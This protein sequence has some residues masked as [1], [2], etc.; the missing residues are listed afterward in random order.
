M[1]TVYRFYYGDEYL[2]YGKHL[3]YLM[4]ISVIIS[5]Y[6]MDRIE[7]TFQSVNSILGQKDSD[8]EI[9]VV[10]DRNAELVAI[11]REHF[12]DAIRI[13]VSDKKG[14]SRA[15]NLG[16]KH[17]K[18][19]IVAFIDDD[20][21]A[22]DGWVEGIR[23]ALSGDP[24]IGA[25]T[26]PIFPEWLGEE[27]K[28]FPKELNWMI[29]C[30]YSDIEDGA[31]VD[32]AF[33][34]NMAFRR[35]ILVGLG[36]FHTKLGAVQKW[37]KIK[38]K[39]VTKTGLVGEERHLCLKFRKAGYLI[40]H[41]PEVA[42]NHKV[43][44]YRVVFKNL[45][46]RAYWEGYSKGYIENRFPKKEGEAALSTEQNYLAGLFSNLHKPHNTCGLVDKIRM[47]AMTGFVLA[48]VMFGYGKFK[49]TSR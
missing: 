28:W 32:T 23:S 27:Q 22:C 41:S 17:A 8:S 29:S 7:D 42:I 25:C 30:T 46:D 48:V 45:L 47:Y 13:V 2:L 44:P 35:E 43:Y 24:K 31:F 19:D 20:A 39:W 3:A 40:V 10:I 38:G 49:L 6:G 5:T 16:V 34:T 9:L 15:R 36:G 14:L 1:V 33:G 21:T 26:G 11:L 18:G 12:G 4:R 37:K